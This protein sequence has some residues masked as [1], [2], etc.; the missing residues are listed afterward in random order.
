MMK[1]LLMRAGMRPGVACLSLAVCIF[2]GLGCR[3]AAIEQ[4]LRNFQQVNLVANKAMYDPATVDPTLQNGWGLA[5]APSGI[6]W[7]NAEADGLSELY[8]AAGAI[9]RKPVNIPSPTDTIGGAPIGIVFNSTKGFVLPDKATASFIFDGGDGVISAWNGAAGSNAF[10]IADNAATSA[11]TGLTLAASG[12]ANFLY[13]ANFRTGKIDVWD[14]AWNPVTW[15]P[16]HDAGI[17][18]GFAPFNIQSVGAWLVVNYAKVGANGRQEV[19]AGLGFTD[20]FNTNGS[21]VRRLASRGVLNAPWGVTMAPAA[22]LQQSDMKSSTGGESG[23]GGGSATGGESGSTSGKMDPTQPVILVGNFGDGRIN[24]FT[25]DG[26]FLGQLQSHNR[27]IVID[28]LWALGFA[29]TTATTISQSW[30]F[31]TAGPANQ[32]DGIFGYLVKN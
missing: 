28:G 11:Y 17:P 18:S 7:V 1:N 25:T 4:E 2:L 14:T 29:P 31:F 10:R 6:A 15:M 3:K 23:T 21:F 26:I 22:F 8:T 5:W 16:F 20:I 13:A 32:T 27:P 9:V 30:L 19:G 24:V 12:G